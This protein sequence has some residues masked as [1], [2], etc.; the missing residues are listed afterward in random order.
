[1]KTWKDLIMMI[2]A[3]LCI[4]SLTPLFA[5]STDGLVAWYPFSGNAQDASGNGHHGV[6]FGANIV[7]DRFTTLSRL[8]T[9]TL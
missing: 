3:W 4:V 1:M 7:N 6:V 8:I 2:L 9:S 5:V